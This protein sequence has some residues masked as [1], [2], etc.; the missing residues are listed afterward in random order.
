MASVY[1]LYCQSEKVNS[2]EMS[3]EIS[4]QLTQ[5]ILWTELDSAPKINFDIRAPVSV[6][7][8]TS[9]PISVSIIERVI[10]LCIL[11]NLS[12]LCNL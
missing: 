6:S 5:V 12:I 7:I 2:R 1:D 10:Y 9:V 8:T 4:I 3:F 11:S